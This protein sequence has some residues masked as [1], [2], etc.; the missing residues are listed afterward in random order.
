[1]KLRKKSE[2]EEKKNQFLKYGTKNSFKKG[3]C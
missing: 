2:V 3:K 1:V